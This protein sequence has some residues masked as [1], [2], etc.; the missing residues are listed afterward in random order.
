MG[1]QG[2]SGALPQYG[3]TSPSGFGRYDWQ[4]LHAAAMDRSLVERIRFAEPAEPA[5]QPGKRLFDVVVSLLLIVALSPLLAV[6]AFLARRDGGPALF[7]H[8]RIGAHGGTFKCWKFRSMVPNAQ[9]VLAEHLANNPAAREEWDRDFKLR[10]DPR[11]TRIGRFLRVTSLDELPQLFNVLS[12]E[13]SLVGP[14]PI[15]AAEVAR[16]GAAFHDYQRCRPG[17]T[18]IWQISGRNEVDYR[19]RVRL[20]QRYA[21]NWSLLN[22]L[23]IL[24]RT[25]AAVLRRRGAY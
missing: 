24:L 12:G 1:I 18:G 10:D 13:M 20:D 23:T 25:P 4:R 14:R 16:Y 22:D 19:H 9:A 5:V 21:R 3:A 17:I 6:L 7:G 11:I 15:V 8:T 2:F